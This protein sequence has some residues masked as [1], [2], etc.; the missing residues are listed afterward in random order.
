MTPH[1]LTPTAPAIPASH[2]DPV[3]DIR[4]RTA[5]GTSNPTQD[6]PQ[7]LAH[8]EMLQQRLAAAEAVL[9]GITQLTPGEPVELTIYRAERDHGHMPLGLYTNRAAAR[10]HGEH[11]HARKGLPTRATVTW[12][13]DFGDAAATEELAVFA[14]CEDGEQQEDSATGFLVAP[15]TLKAAYDPDA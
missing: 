3:A 11:L 4:M 8:I 1:T 9:P 7:L 13:P 12:I 10:A 15:L 14:P 2:R 5:A 6:I